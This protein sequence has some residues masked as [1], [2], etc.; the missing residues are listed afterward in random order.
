MSYFLVVLI[1]KNGRN[2]PDN[3]QDTQGSWGMDIRLN[4]DC[5]C[6][7]DRF[8]HMRGSRKDEF[9]TPLLEKM[10]KQS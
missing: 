9:P 8:I 10:H 2:L 1:G 3:L 6:L 5:D 7:L 4:G